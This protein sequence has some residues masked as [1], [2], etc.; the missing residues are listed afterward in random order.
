MESHIDKLR[1]TCT[2]VGL[3]DAHF[4]TVCKEL[5]EVK[6]QPEGVTY[7]FDHPKEVL[8]GKPAAVQSILSR[9]R[10]MS[11]TETFAFPTQPMEVSTP[12]L[13]FADAWDAVHMTAALRDIKNQWER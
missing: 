10:A 12:D 13:S 11:E 1:F 7:V 4:D 8:T 2:D 3:P 5:K 9:A 6:R